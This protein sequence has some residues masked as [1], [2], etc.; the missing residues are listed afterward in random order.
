MFGVSRLYVPFALFGLYKRGLFEDNFSFRE[1]KYMFRIVVVM[2][3]IDL[4]GHAMFKYYTIPV[5]E[6]HTSIN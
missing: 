6:K 2:H 5:V 1:V 3:M 4:L